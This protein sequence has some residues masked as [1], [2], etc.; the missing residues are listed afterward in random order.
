M[1]RILLRVGRE[2][3]RKS[4]LGGN[5]IYSWRTYSKSRRSIEIFHRSTKKKMCLISI[6]YLYLN[7]V[8]KH[9]IGV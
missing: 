8:L 9:L 4:G 2:T 1:V 7:K 3:G 6:F 5:I